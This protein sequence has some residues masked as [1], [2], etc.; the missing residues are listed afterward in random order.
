MAQR[1]AIGF[2]RQRGDQLEVVNLQFAAA[3]DVIDVAE[4]TF[5]QQLFA[6]SK[7][8]LVRFA[9]LGVF[10]I[11]TL[12]VLFIVIRPMMRQV[13]APEK[14]AALKNA[15]G[16]GGPAP[17]LAG[18]AGQLALPSPTGELVQLG[19][20]NG[21]VQAASIQKVGEVVKE[22]PAEAVAVLR[23]WMNN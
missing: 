1:P 3:P 16:M 23:G 21:G 13:I 10:A 18:P 8:D 19:N 5:F 2:D 14:I 20:V 6:F 9:E 11:L 12:L 22:N 17:Q 4:P 15:V 7:D